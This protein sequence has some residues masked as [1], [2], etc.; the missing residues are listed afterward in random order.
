MEKD[1]RYLDK[2]NNKFLKIGEQYFHIDNIARIDFKKQNE[3]AVNE[4][5]CV[6]ISTTNSSTEIVLDNLTDGELAVLQLTLND[7]KIR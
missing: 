2:P 1:D 4:K 3:E 6:C 5:V 7:L